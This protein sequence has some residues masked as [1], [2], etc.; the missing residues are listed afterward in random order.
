MRQ[1]VKGDR[2]R[3]KT[4]RYSFVAKTFEGC[5]TVES[6]EGVDGLTVRVVIDG[7][8]EGYPYPAEILELCQ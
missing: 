8:T 5:G 4:P 6:V 3:H 2:V 1:F 7:Q